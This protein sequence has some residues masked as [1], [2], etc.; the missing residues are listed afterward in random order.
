MIRSL[1]LLS[2][3]L[4]SLSGCAALV[5]GGAGAVGVAS[6]KEG[7]LSQS[8]TDT[9]IQATINDLW[10]RQDFDIFRKLDLTVN[11]GRVLITGTVQD[12]EHRVD[13]VRL[14]WKAS[15][16]KQVINEITVAESSG[17]TGYLSDTWINTQLRTG[18]A[19]DEDIQ[20]LNYSIDAVK[21][22]VYLMGV[23]QNRDELNKVIERART[24]RGVQQVVS[25]VK[26]HGRG[27][28]QT[29]T[30]PRVRTTDS[31]DFNTNTPINAQDFR[32]GFD[33]GPDPLANDRPETFPAAGP[34]P[35]VS[36]PLPLF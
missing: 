14:A 2:F 23:A 25:Y 24:I 35:V 12:P 3:C 1:L 36:E 16:V 6:V 15:G 31:V 13:A 28:I 10:F 29:A 18:M 22:N 26:L 27:E 11:Q 33:P 8:L 21:G 32:G 17:F 7:G 5:V 9:R 4:V 30:Q 20:N 34:A 19:L